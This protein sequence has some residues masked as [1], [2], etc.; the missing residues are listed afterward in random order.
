MARSASSGYK[1]VG[2]KASP[3]P[4]AIWQSL[5]LAVRTCC[6]ELFLVVRKLVE[7]N[8]EFMRVPFENVIEVRRIVTAD[9]NGWTE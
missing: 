9:G 2:R 4:S 3:F 8:V 7:R 1:M 6:V 5:R